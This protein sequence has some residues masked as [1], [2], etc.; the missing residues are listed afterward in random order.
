ME[1]GDL[2]R[3]RGDLIDEAARVLHATFLGR[4]DDWQDLDSARAEVLDSLATDRVSRVALDDGGSVI[5][6]IGAIPSYGGRV[7]EIHPLVVSPS[8]RRRG[9]GRALVNDAERIVVGRGGLTLWLVIVG[10]MQ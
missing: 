1:I 4:T 10:A 8:H 3:Q 2:T 5:G 9:I 6:W 7:W